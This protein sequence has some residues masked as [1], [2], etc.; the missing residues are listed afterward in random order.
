MR[1]GGVEGTVQREV[2]GTRRDGDEGRSLG[3]GVMVRGGAWALGVSRC[4]SVRGEAVL[5]ESVE[6]SG[7]PAL[8]GAHTQT[9]APTPPLSE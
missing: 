2:L 4:G 3:C 5:M 8:G 6:F 1:A 7:V 9:L